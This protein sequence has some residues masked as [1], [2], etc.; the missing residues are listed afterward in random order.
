MGGALQMPDGD[1]E[2]GVRVSGPGVRLV[3]AFNGAD[4]LNVRPSE[5]AYTITLSFI[6]TGSTAGLTTIIDLNS[7]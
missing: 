1:G 5:D 6:F 4:G 7:G 2:P 3:A